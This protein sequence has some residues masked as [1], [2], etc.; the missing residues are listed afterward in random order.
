MSIRIIAESGSELS[1]LKHPNLTVL[2]LTITFGSDVYQDGVDL[3]PR[4]FYELLEKSDV[5]P[6]TGGVTPYDFGCAIKAARDAGEDVVVITISSKLSG[7]YGNAVTAAEAFPGVRVV[8]SL[9]ASLGEQVFVRHALRLVEKGLGVEELV[10]RLEEDRHRVCL[11]ALLDTLEYLRR[12]GRIPAAAAKLG[13]LLS[14]KPVV[15]VVHGEGTACL[16]GQ[17]H[18]LKAGRKVVDKAMEKLGGID[19]SLPWTLAYNGLNGDPLAAYIKE[20]H[21]AWQGIGVA[22]KDLPICYAGA[23][24]GVHA[25]PDAMGLAFFHR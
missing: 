21:D 3:S 13:N 18:G 17:A 2:P 19:F 22:E 11:I 10:A 16:L 7:T 15:G 25:G 14:I 5:N 24:I 6:T 1:A 9:N 4:Q 20:R 12:G 8:D 23:T